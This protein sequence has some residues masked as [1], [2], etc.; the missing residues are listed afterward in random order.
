M[1]SE[2]TSHR[3]LEFDLYAFAR[4]AQFI[5]Y[6]PNLLI[7][8]ASFNYDCTISKYHVFL[9]CMSSASLDETKGMTQN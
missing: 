6:L 1:S 7:K 2:F 8:S 4:N 9:V 5:G 3:Y